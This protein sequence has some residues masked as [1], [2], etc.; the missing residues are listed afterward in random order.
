MTDKAPLFESG[1]T[2]QRVLAG[3]D[4]GALLAARL[5]GGRTSTLAGLILAGLPLAPPAQRPGDSKDELTARTACGLL[6]AL[7]RRHTTAALGQ[8][9][10]RHL[11]NDELPDSLLRHT[12]GRASPATRGGDRQPVEEWNVGQTRE[13]AANCPARER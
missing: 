6:E 13:Q 7:V 1:G 9:T 3:T 10:L 12:T 4:S 11:L 8:V 2:G 5:A